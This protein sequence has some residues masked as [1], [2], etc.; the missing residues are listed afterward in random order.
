MEGNLDL[1]IVTLLYW[2]AK[3]ALLLVSKSSLKLTTILNEHIC[4]EYCP[5]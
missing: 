3:T 4:V 5:I 1:N 2:G